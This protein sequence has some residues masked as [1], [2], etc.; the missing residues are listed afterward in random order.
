VVRDALVEAL[1]ERGWVEGNNIA[2]EW[3]GAEGSEAR[4][5]EHLA[6]TPADV[7]VC[8]GPHRIRA[9]M[10]LAD[11]ATHPD[12]F[13]A[14]RGGA[15]YR[16]ALALAE[17][18]GMRPLMAHCLGKVYRRLGQHEQAREHLSTAATMYRDV[19]MRFW[20]EQAEA[21]LRQ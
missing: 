21:Q 8:G 9:A 3:H 5:A 7:L 1:R 14:D 2:F 10:R 12:R 16:E 15:H 4:I 17:P 11:S 19:D 13:D 20:L 18:R 6:S